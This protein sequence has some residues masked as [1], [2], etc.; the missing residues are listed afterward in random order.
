MISFT[1]NVLVWLHFFIRIA[2]AEENLGESE[3]R[4]AHLAKS[5]FYIR[6][7][8]KV[9]NNY[10]FQLSSRLFGVYPYYGVLHLTCLCMNPG[11]GSGTT[12]ANRKQD[13]RSGA[14]DGLGILYA[15]AWFF[16]YGFQSYFQEH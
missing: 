13:S 10:D 12:K 14:K 4:E 15:A 3:V 6:I 8:D 11:K 16:L 9:C 2:D 5:L 1:S 7:G